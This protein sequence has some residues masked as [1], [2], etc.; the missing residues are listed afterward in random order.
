MAL[1]AEFQRRL[2][3]LGLPDPG[4]SGVFNWAERLSERAEASVVSLRDPKRER[5]ADRVVSFLADDAFQIH[6]MTFDKRG[7]FAIIRANYRYL[8]MAA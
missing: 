1:G 8:K 6:S 5:N 7:A 3:V 4:P 2:P